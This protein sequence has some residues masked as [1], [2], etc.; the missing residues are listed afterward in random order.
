L[1]HAG[2]G[3]GKRN[4]IRRSDYWL[5]IMENQSTLEWLYGLETMG[6]K[7]GLS[8]ITE[9]LHRL[10]DPQQ[11]FRAVHV[12]GTNG[13][14]SVSA[15]LASV[16]QEQGY[17]TGLYTSPHLVDFTERIQVDG[18]RIS[19][20]D[21]SHLAE[22]VRGHVEDMYLVNRDSHPTFFEVATALAF[23]HYAE[24]GVQEAVVEVGMGGRLDATNVI[25]PDCS[26]IT[27]IALEH[28]KYLGDTLAKIAWEKAGIIKPGVPVVTAEVEGEAFEA[29]EEV[30]MERGAPLFS[31][32]PGTDYRIVDCSLD[33]TWVY[34]PGMG[35]QVKLPLI[36]AYQAANVGIAYA[37][38]SQLRSKGVEVSDSAFRSG[39]GKVRWPGRLEIVGRH[40]TVIFDATHTP[41]GAEAVS[42]DLRDL[43][44]GRIILILGI[45]DDK[46]LEGIAR[47]F[48][49]IADRA[50][51]TQPLTP[52]AIPAG[53][54]QEAL[55]KFMGRVESCPSV[56]EA[57][58]RGIS[59]AG[60]EDTVLVTGSIYTLGEA[61]AWWDANEGREKD[62]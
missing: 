32:S 2:A 1:P 41:Q 8:N 62:T 19:M 59:I 48:A 56:V 3:A 11:S 54:V 23:L 17:R 16:L 40:P 51:A 6:I 58:R 47:P 7:L 37:A 27:R 24:E 36:G 29:I 15:M 14:G 13:K 35:G 60:P 9:L 53:K 43:I 30:A 18:V 31:V 57:V 44:Q 22:E 34:L 26:V 50:I 38:V 33:G 49:A 45:L 55:S 39:I 25:D 5:D 28:T 20:H 42:N 10:G 61:K 46:D 21:L 12:A 52:R 4:C